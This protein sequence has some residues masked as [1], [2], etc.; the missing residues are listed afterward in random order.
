MELLDWIAHQMSCSLAIVAVGLET[1]MEVEQSFQWRTPEPKV[2]R[3]MKKGSISHGSKSSHKPSLL[4]F[5]Y[6]TA[7]I[8]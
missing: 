3:N 7:I 1:R 5:S 4:L 6:N 8:T 2:L